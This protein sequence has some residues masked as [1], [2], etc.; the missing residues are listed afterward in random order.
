MRG[1]PRQIC[2]FVD[3]LRHVVQNAPPHDITVILTDANAIVS[4]SSRSDATKSAIG[5]SF[6]DSCTNDNGRRLNLC[7]LN[8]LSIVDTWFPKKKIH[9]WTWY[10]PDRR[11]RK[12][13]DHIIVTRGWRSF[14]TNARV[15]CGAQLGNT[16][17]RVCGDLQIENK[18]LPTNTDFTASWLVPA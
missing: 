10:S 3:K 13:L 17:H 15:Y 12:A 5:T 1:R 14:V 11:T 18:T 2:F 8:D 4:C 7:G 6:V 9:Q 16:D